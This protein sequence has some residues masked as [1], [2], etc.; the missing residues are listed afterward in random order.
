[1]SVFERGVTRVVV[2]RVAVAVFF[3]GE[4]AIELFRSFVKE[5]RS[6][7]DGRGDGY[8]LAGFL[9]VACMHR[10]GVRSSFAFPARS[11]FGVFENDPLFEEFVAD[12]I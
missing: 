9:A 11:F 5:A 10:S 3:V 2:A 4:D 6:G 8:L 7:V 1:M 12:G